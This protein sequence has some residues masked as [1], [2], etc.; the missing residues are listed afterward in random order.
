MQ[1]GVETYDEAKQFF[2]PQLTDLH[3]PFLMMDM[4]KAIARIQSALANKERIL[5]YGD[6][7]VDGTTAVSTV[8]SFFRKL[9]SNIEF[10]IPDRYKEG[11]GISK[12][13][14]DY[15]VSTDVK[16]IIALDCGTR[17]VELIASATENGIDFIV[18]DHH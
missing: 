10:Y 3:D 4:D 13:G 2:R 15:A 7:D 12:I 6:Y 11:Y 17:S 5:I 8:F 1:R 14:I 9:T 18:C 16:L